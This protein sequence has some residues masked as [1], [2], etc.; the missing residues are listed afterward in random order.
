MQE[1]KRYGVKPVYDDPENAHSGS[2]YFSF[3]KAKNYNGTGVAFRLYN[4]D[5]PGNYIWLEANSQYRITYYVNFKWQDDPASELRTV[6]FKSYDGT[7]LET[8]D[9]VEFRRA[10]ETDTR[11]WRIYKQS[12]SVPRN[13]NKTCG[14][15]VKFRTY[16]SYRCYGSD[17]VGTRRFVS[18]KFVG[19]SEC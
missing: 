2:N 7:D 5:S 19:T 16:C 12:F 15:V 8:Y 18:C 9:V 4:A 10:D 3:Y 13:H 6:G 11:G 14:L 1:Q 17:L